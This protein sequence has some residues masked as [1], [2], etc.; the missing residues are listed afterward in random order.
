MDQWLYTVSAD[1]DYTEILG[2]E[3]DTFDIPDHVAWRV[4][5]LADVYEIDL[6]EA[7]QRGCDSLGLRCFLRLVS[8]GTRPPR[9]S[10]FRNYREAHGAVLDLHLRR[11]AHNWRLASTGR[12]TNT[13]KLVTA[14]AHRV[15]GRFDSLPAIRPRS[16]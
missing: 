5:F 1:H 4:F 3:V 2:E 10:A 6:G 7:L 9:A 13:E 11:V 15:V 8:L 12:T 14:W 16:L